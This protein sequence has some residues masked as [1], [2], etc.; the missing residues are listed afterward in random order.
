MSQEF[1]DDEG[2]PWLLV[3]GFL[4]LCLPMFLF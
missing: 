2:C 1:P 4:V 3:L